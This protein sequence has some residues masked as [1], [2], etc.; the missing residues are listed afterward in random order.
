MSRAR[1][2]SRFE[3]AV[4]VGLAA[5]ICLLLGLNFA[6]NYVVYRARTAE[7]RDTTSAFRQA[8]IAASR[9]VQEAYPSTASPDEIKR[10]KTAFVLTELVVIPISPAENKGIARR[11]WLREMVRRYSPSTDPALMERLFKGQPGEVTRGVGDSYDYVYIIPSGAGRSMLLLSAERPRL[12]YLED[13]RPTLILV[14]M[15]ALAVVAVAWVG[16][17]RMIFRPFRR[18]RNRAEAAGRTIAA[19]ED[20]SEAIVSEY[21]SV[22]Q[23]LRQQQQ[24]LV[25]LNEE[26][27]RKV[28]SL[29]DF[30]QYLVTTSQSGLITLDVAGRIMAAND[31]AHRL[32]RLTTSGVAGRPFEAA[33]SEHDQLCGI[34]RDTISG[35][36]AGGYRELI[37]T[38]SE[39]IEIV[40]GV[41]LSLI[42]NRR[43]REVGLLMVVND[44]TELHRLKAEVEDGRRLAALGEMAAGLAHQFRNSLGAISGYGTLLKKHFNNVEK[45]GLYAEQ[46]LEECRDA[47]SLVTRFLSF[48]RPLDFSPV[49]CRLEAAA[50]AAVAQIR[51]CA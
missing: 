44:L 7:Q 5:I 22:I 6:S 50:D 8:A 34:V 29:E 26:I 3:I 28:D 12:A 40:L 45:P 14:M 4:H 25:H 27:Q 23:Q 20:D 15:A 47:E 2:K 1:L 41:T 13:A 35:E 37:E 33:L 43:K 31:T 30:N 46:L 9:V 19:D 17:S 51:A 21:E 32:L 24:E 36:L 49:S 16:L 10:L 38:D 18:L 11:D 42:L 48:A 39:G